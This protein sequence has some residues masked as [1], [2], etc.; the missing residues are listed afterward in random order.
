MTHL[1]EMS[2]TERGDAIYTKDELLVA[3][4]GTVPHPQPDGPLIDLAELRIGD[5]W[6]RAT[7]P[8]GR[9]AYE[10]VTSWTPSARTGDLAPEAGQSAASEA[11]EPE[12]G[13]G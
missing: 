3:P 4:D 13:D 6:M 1:F 2:V 11:A 8:S 5:G 9:A 10:G 7:A 12:G